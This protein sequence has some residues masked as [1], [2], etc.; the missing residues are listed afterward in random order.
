[1]FCLSCRKVEESHT[2]ANIKLW[3]RQV[4]EEYEIKDT[5]FIVFSADS[6]ANIQKA[7]KLFLADLKG[8]TF[9]VGVPGFRGFDDDEE[10]EED[11]ASDDDE[12]EEGENNGAVL[13]P[14]N[15]LEADAIDD[16]DDFE[17]A[18]DYNDVQLYGPLA[19]RLIPQSYRVGCVVHQLQLAVNK[20]CESPLISRMLATA[21]SLAA[22][23]RTR[24]VA[25]V[26]ERDYKLKAV[27]DQATRWSSKHR[28]TTRLAQ[29]KDFYDDNSLTSKDL[30]GGNTFNFVQQNKSFN[31]PND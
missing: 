21:R 7:A 25:R 23:M 22:K 24:K 6:A 19:Q 2:A 4:I 3:I 14:H 10:E 26:M 18:P 1:M 13:T 12:S 5:Q 31:H 29:L 27:I 9:H 28:M 17:Y 20:W 15:F 8:S 16:E 11:S 30:L